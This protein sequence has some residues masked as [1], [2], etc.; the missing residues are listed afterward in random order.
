[1]TSNYYEVYIEACTQLAETLIIKSVDTQDGLN[2][3]VN[4]Q[5]ALNGTP[6]VDELN[7]ESWKYYLNLSGQ[8]H[9]LDTMMVV[10]SLDTLQPINFTLENL[11]IHTAT[12]LAYQYGTRLYQVLLSN[13]PNQ[14]MLIK[15][16]LYPVDINVAINAEEGTILGYPPTLVEPNEYSLI[17]N[18]QKWIN[19]FKVRWTNVQYGVSDVLY[20]ATAL[21]IMYLNLLPAILTARLQACKT[22]EAHSFHVRQYLASH[23]LLNSYI[24]NMTL[25]QTLFFYRNISYIERNSGK[26]AVFDWLI[27]NVLTV[28]GLPISEYRMRHDLTNQPTNLYPDVVFYKN[29]LNHQ[30]TSNTSNNLTVQ[31]VLINE[32]PLAPNNITYED[33]YSVSIEDQMENSLFN[34][35]PTK[36]LESSLIDD[37][38]SGPYSLTEILLNSWIYFSTNG[39]YNTFVTISNPKTGTGILLSTIDAYTLAFY[40]FCNSVGINP[41]EVPTVLANRVQRIIPQDHNSLIQ[42]SSIVSINDIMSVVDPKVVDISV[43]ELA[44]SM[45]PEIRTIISTK[46]FYKTCLQIHA[47]AAMQRNLISSQEL[48]LQ[49]SMVFSMV[50]RIYS[51]NMCTLAPPNTLY[52]KWLS[53]RNIDI[54]GLTTQE[55]DVF[56]TNL[57][58]AATGANLFTSHSLRDIQSAMLNIM[59]QLSSYSVQFIASINATSDTKTDWTAIRV[60]NLSGSISESINVL[61]LGAG[62]MNVDG[63]TNDAV[64]FPIDLGN[65]IEVV[66]TESIMFVNDI[67]SISPLS[68]FNNAIDQITLPFNVSFNTN[69][70][71]VIGSTNVNF[72]DIYGFDPTT[73]I[74]ESTGIVN[75]YGYSDGALIPGIKVSSTTPTNKVTVGGYPTD[76]GV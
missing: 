56:Y 45:Q 62:V 9:P 72:V 73:I 44:L 48:M 2:N 41:V 25:S 51:D 68:I 19:G 50:S 13:Y 31:E 34:T 36:I 17:S 43:A 18:I 66:N 29:S 1:M 21:G 20:P 65:M 16:I 57:V 49:R 4:D 24:D 33:D 42:T 32:Q 40:V 14:E 37:T 23:N 28:R 76:Y 59:S 12:A 10:T 71:T 74:T 38:N 60:D 55:L 11:L 35:L 22:N 47:A 7:S 15:G 58:N 63:T 70:S 6:I 26:Q 3:W 75:E 54:S 69:L 67:Q 53:D 52:S 61:D 8:Y 39:N 27:Y 46:N 30:F 5:A 64:S